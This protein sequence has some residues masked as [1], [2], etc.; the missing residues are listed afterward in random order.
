MSTVTFRGDSQRTR[1]R[2]CSAILLDVI[3]D[4]RCCAGVR[5]F[6]GYVQLRWWT[7]AYDSDD[8]QR[9]LYYR[10]EGDCCLSRRR[11]V[12]ASHGDIPTFGCNTEYSY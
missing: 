2:T 3:L 1:Q 6:W 5:S 7:Q 8:M 10:E 11:P 12:D 4:F 9:R